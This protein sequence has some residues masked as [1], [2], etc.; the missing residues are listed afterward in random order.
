MSVKDDSST[1]GN[2]TTIGHAK[3]SR[4]TYKDLKMLN[5]PRLSYKLALSTIA[6]CDMNS[7]F[8]QVER[9][10]LGLTD[11]DPVVC[12]QWNS[13]IAVSYA[14]RKFGINRMD[15][16]QS[17]KEKCPQVILAH[18]AVFKKGNS[19]WSYYDELPQ[20]DVCKVSLDPY[21]REGR[22]IV[23]IYKKHCDLV[24][25]SS[26]DESYLDLGRL[27]YTKLMQLFPQLNNGIDLDPLPNIPK[28]L[29][30][31]LQWKG[32]IIESELEASKN[33][34]EANSSASHIESKSSIEIIDW[35]DICML[36][37]SQLLFNI[38]KHIYDELGYTT[39]G[40]LANNKLVAKLAAGFNKPDCQTI[41]RNQLI[42]K[43]LTNFKLQDVTGLGG[44]LGD[45]IYEKFNL[46]EVN[47]I[48][49][50][51]DNFTLKDIEHEFQNDLPFAKKLHEIVR[52]ICRVELTERSDIKSMMS[53]KNFMSKAPVAT[54]G[55]AY[56]WL[57][58]F[59][60]D[61]YN[62]MIELDEET[63]NLS[64]F[65]F[66]SKAH[67]VRRPKTL[68][69]QITTVN[70]ST[71]SKQMK[72]PVCSSLQQLKDAIQLGSL[73][74]LKHLLDSICNLSLLNGGRP[75]KELLHD[76][77]LNKIKCIK[78][79]SMGLVISNFV[80]TN[81]SSS[82]DLFTEK[83]A[84]DKDSIL[85]AFS[86]FNDSRVPNTAS[87][88][89]TN[90]PNIDKE[91]ISKLFADYK[92]E[93][94]SMQSEINK[95]VVP[96]HKVDKEYINKLFDDFKKENL[97]EAQ[98]DIRAKSNVNT[99][100]IP[101]LHRNGESKKRNSSKYLKLPSKKLKSGK[102]DIVANLRVSQHSKDKQP[103]EDSKIC[104]KCEN[105]IENTPEHLDYHFALELSE[106]INT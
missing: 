29:P 88:V 51:R 92:R 102:S 56:D 84:E 71:R 9:A 33:Q 77:N 28:S 5:D 35:D 80:K 78:I 68:S 18:A 79:V 30:D 16:V 91:Y 76:P 3:G 8:A 55:D 65:D 75:I 48:A 67:V 104:P 13:L 62:R 74:L 63:M 95:P 52:G 31:E 12:V 15:N 54:F 11:D 53:R 4:F 100:T 60:G 34:L 1:T 72:L 20:Q 40:G 93:D 82:I 38:R 44:K 23:N 21:R 6:L 58:V 36:I 89:L 73:D 24:E 101:Q 70:Y 94:I 42:D 57:L 90:P 96:K 17:A 14:A 85:K 47:S 25:K 2:L 41:I 32:K 26:V 98:K 61:L 45:S 83:S 69:I 10:R 39:S 27:V 99:T 66:N 81:T 86:E 87:E 43:F 59:A 97:P 7:F 105:Q 49:Y 46:P 106:R 19:Y 22:K 50:L 64:M 37:G 103:P